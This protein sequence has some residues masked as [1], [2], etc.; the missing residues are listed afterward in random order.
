MHR[1]SLNGS[2]LHHDASV[3]HNDVYTPKCHASCVIAVGHSLLRD[4]WIAGQP[5]YS[6]CTD[7]QPGQ[8]TQIAK[9]NLW[10]R[11][12]HGQAQNMLDLSDARKLW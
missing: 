8:A 2:H 11:H 5:K 1:L 10:V 4:V 6:L 9:T 7:E 3:A 12:V